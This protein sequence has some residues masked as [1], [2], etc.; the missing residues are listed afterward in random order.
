MDSYYELVFEDGTRRKLDNVNS[1]ES[2]KATAVSVA[3]VTK[4][5][6]KLQKVT[7]VDPYA[8]PVRRG[9]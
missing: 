4:T 8:A 5:K 3:E 7:P 1:Q 6:V 2:A 9:S